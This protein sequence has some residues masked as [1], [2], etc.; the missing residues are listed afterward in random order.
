[1]SASF[2]D[3]DSAGLS[4]SLELGVVDVLGVVLLLQLRPLC[5]LVF[6]QVTDDAFGSDL[7]VLAAYKVEF[8]F[9]F[10]F[11]FAHILTYISSTQ[12]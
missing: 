7:L 1:M 2:L 3:F 8:E 10:T 11:D 9:S 5:R 12:S 6:D 4:L